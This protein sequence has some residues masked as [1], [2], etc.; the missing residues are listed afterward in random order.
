MKD[1]KHLAKD[2][3]EKR[4]LKAEIMLGA[5]GIIYLIIV[6]GLVAYYLI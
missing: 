1:Y 5:V 4:M 6:A 2:N 3:A